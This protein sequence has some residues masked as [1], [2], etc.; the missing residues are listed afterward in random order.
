MKWNGPQLRSFLTAWIVISIVG[1]AAPAL[2]EED[3]APIL[4]ATPQKNQFAF[5]PVVGYSEGD[6]IR[7]FAA[8]LR[9]L[10]LFK[11]VIGAIQGQAIFAKDGVVY[12][13]GIDVFGRYGPFYGGP[14]VAGVWFPGQTGSPIATL[15]LQAGIH[16]PSPFAGTFF[17]VAY[18]PNILLLSNR[19]LV[20]HL[21]T[22]GLVL[23]TGG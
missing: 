13:G 4:W 3:D 17:D 1:A 5:N 23:E 2:A 14:G 9:G 7:G 12:N 18:R 8:S 6:S 19:Q 20:Y 15:A 22:V 21:V 16:L 10:F 11:Y